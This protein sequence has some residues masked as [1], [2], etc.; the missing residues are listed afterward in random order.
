MRKKFVAKKIL[1]ATE[2]LVATTTDLI[3]FLTILPFSLS[4][5][6]GQMDASRRVEDVLKLVKEDIN[7][8]TI[9]NA[10]SKLV[11]A[12]LITKKSKRNS[13]DIAITMLGQQ[14]IEAII[15]MY[16]ETRPWD[17]H[18]YLVSYDVPAKPKRK[19]DLLRE[20]LRRIGAILLQ[21]SLWL[22]PYNPR[23][24][25]NDFANSHKI[26]GSILVSRLGTDGGIGEE[27]LD[28]LIRRVYKLD[29]LNDRYAE[30][31]EIYESQRKP[32]SLFTLSTTYFAILKDD[33]Q[34]PF[35]LL[36]P[37]FLGEK[38]YRVYQSF[39]HNI[40]S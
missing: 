39:I 19:R 15:P 25:I 27:K 11:A 36:P 26:G 3:L 21:E 5:A 6:H 1:Q 34:L 2:G 22:T 30:F 17:G 9:K 16:H 18:L 40:A 8:R 32:K 13:L 12:G 10:I 24:I 31:I 20:Y 7:Y 33:P 29:A 35:E 23:D 4:G 37:D 38:A 14:R 28:S